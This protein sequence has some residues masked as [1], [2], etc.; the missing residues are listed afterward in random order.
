MARVFLLSV[1]WLISSNRSSNQFIL[2]RSIPVHFKST[3]N[4]FINSDLR[5]LRI[6][7]WRIV[8]QKKWWLI[9]DHVSQTYHHKSVLQETKQI[10]NCGKFFLLLRRRFFKS[11]QYLSLS[12]GFMFGGR[13]RRVYTNQLWS[14]FWGG[15]WHWD[16]FPNVLWEIAGRLGKDEQL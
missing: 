15:S 11:H 2:I 9:S 5:P 10:I 14:F 12:F 3:S 16:P 6:H 4:D 7:T 8:Y 13:C 1:V